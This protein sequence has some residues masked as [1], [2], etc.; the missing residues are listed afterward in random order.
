HVDFARSLARQHLGGKRVQP[1][2]TPHPSD[3]SDGH[4]PLADKSDGA[5]PPTLLFAITV[6]RVT[7]HHAIR[8]PRNRL[9][10]QAVTYPLKKSA[11]ELRSPK[12]CVV[13]PA[14]AGTQRAALRGFSSS[15]SEN[16]AHVQ[17]NCFDPRLLGS[18]GVVQE[19]A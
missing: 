17:T 9:L 5:S 14:K 6:S 11:S 10:G 1:R 18:G 13:V 3:R 15:D 7:M 16:F 8:R 4:G 2:P 12:L 19:L